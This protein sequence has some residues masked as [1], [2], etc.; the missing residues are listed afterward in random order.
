MCLKSRYVKFPSLDQT[1]IFAVALLPKYI[2][3]VVGSK[4]STSARKSFMYDMKSSVIRVG[5]AH[6]LFATLLEYRAAM[7]ITKTM[8]QM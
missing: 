8:I 7:I 3:N 1:L 5:T 6:R 2:V 4:Q